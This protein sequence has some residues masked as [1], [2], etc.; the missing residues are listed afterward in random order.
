[1]MYMVLVILHLLGA[2]VW[3]GGHVVLVS[4]VMPM[5][6]RERDPGRIVDFERGYGRVGMIA[7]V[8]QLA[9]GIWLADHWL[10]GWQNIFR[11]PTPAAHLVLLKVALL[12]LT[13][14]LGGHAYHRILPRLDEAGMKR[15]ALHAWAITI[16]AVLMLVVGASIRLGGP[17]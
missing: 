13:L 6:R 9:T 1:M 3:I 14:V 8:V 4:V 11:Q 12:T 5:A 7:L 10:G 17:L 16:L 15:F 2:S